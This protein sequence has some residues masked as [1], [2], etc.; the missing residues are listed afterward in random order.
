MC[1]QDSGLT[2]RRNDLVKGAQVGRHS[3]L[4]NLPELRSQSELDIAAPQAM[5]P[6]KIGKCI[7]W[8]RWAGFFFVITFTS[9]AHATEVCMPSGELEAALID[10][11]GER[12]VE[13]SSGNIVLWASQ[14][15]ETWTIVQYNVDGTA[16]TLEQGSNWNGAPAV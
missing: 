9:A 8:F 12:P 10:W 16:C 7:K 15:G 1:I 3:K 5:I 13:E 11:Y 6:S 2:A 14:G 4:H